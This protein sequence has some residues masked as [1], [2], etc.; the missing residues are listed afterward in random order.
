MNYRIHWRNVVTGKEDFSRRPLSQD[1]A[2]QL[3]ERMNLSTEYEHWVEEIP[4]QPEGWI[5]EDE[6]PPNYP[7]AHM[8]P[9]S[10]IVDGV[11]MFPEVTR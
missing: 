2:E 4:P 1:E 8:F 7:Y 6:L 3:C 11:R 5:Y 10:K 9:E